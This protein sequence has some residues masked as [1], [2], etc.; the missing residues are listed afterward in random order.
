MVKH[1]MRQHFHRQL[2]ELWKKDATLALFATGK[3]V[4]EDN[5]T[6]IRTEETRMDKIAKRFVVANY[7][8]L[9]LV[10]DELKMLCHLDILFF[11]REEPGHLVVKPKD[12]YGGDLDNRMKVLFDALRVPCDVHELPL[13]S[14]PDPENKE[15]PFFYCLLEDDSLISKLQVESVTLLDP[16]KA[17]EEKDVRLVI[18]VTTRV[19][20]LTIG[21]L[22]FLS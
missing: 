13:R 11:R 8:F 15:L 22:G 21:N 16:P 10:T 20:T 9:P 5:S 1:K 19:T 17:R 2:A 6:G 14:A 3:E 18:K 12:V 7:R 4:H